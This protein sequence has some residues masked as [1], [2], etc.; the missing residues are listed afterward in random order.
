MK[1]SAEAFLL[2]LS[3]DYS[4]LHLLQGQAQAD[5]GPNIDFRR[6]Q[7]VTASKPTSSS[8]A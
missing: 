7:I 6:I 3:W 1:N 4:F 5:E 2:L 8:L